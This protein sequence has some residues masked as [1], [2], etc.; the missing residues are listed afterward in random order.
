MYV[1]SKNMFLPSASQSQPWAR[2]IHMRTHKA[3]EATETTIIGWKT[4]IT[5]VV[6]VFILKVD[7]C[8]VIKSPVII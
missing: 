3:F 1:Q 5:L 7:E 8:H 6:F 2:P 4:F